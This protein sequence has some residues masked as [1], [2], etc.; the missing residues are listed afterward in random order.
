[1]FGRNS[2]FI[3]QDELEETFGAKLVADDGY[4]P[5][6]NIAPGAPL[7]VIT[8][9]ATDEIDQCHWGLIPS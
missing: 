5:R 6:Y 3:T 1:M 2:L 9:E 7:E 8:N 4:M